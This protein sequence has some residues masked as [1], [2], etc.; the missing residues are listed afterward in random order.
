MSDKFYFDGF[1]GQSG[2]SY[3]DYK[4]TP[5]SLNQKKWNFHEKQAIDLSSI[6]SAVCK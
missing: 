6:Y 1:R 3:E 5:H 4:Y 2:L